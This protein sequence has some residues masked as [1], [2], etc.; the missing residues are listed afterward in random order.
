VNTIREEATA[1]AFLDPK[2]IDQMR[3]SINLGQIQLVGADLLD[4]KPM[5]VYQYTLDVKSAVSGSPDVKG[6]FK[7]WIGAT[8]SRAY[9]IEGDTDSLVSAGSKVHMSITFEYDIPITIEPPT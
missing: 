2:N 4:G 7:I 3:T 6:T 1:F 5:L 8:D 9:K